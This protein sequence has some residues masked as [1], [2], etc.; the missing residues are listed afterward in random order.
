MAKKYKNNGKMYLGFWLLLAIS[1]LMVVGLWTVYGVWVAVDTYGMELKSA[2]VWK[3]FYK[4]LAWCGLLFATPL[5]V[6]L[7][8]GKKGAKALGGLI[9]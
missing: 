6:L 5:I 3:V 8:A 1:F 9:K 2:L 7:I 4:K